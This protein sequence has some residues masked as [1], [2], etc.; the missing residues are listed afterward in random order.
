MQVVPTGSNKWR[1]LIEIEIEITNGARKEVVIHSNWPL[2]SRSMAP[3]LGPPSL[4]NALCVALLYNVLFVF[5]VCMCLCVYFC[6]K[7]EG[8]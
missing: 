6:F 2:A 8:M 4:H 1:Q 3:K 5:L 7:P